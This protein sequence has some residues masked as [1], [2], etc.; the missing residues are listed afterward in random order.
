M[1]K[2]TNA[3][4]PD[5]INDLIDND[6]NLS[7]AGIKTFIKDLKLDKKAD[8][9]GGKVPASQL[10]SYVDDV[11]EFDTFED[12]P[13]P[14][15]EGKI[16]VA[17]DTGYTYRWSGERYVYIGTFSP[18]KIDYDT[19]VKDIPLGFSILQYGTLFFFAVANPAYIQKYV[20]LRLWDYQ[21]VYDFGRASKESSLGDIL[22]DK[23][24]Y[25]YTMKDIDEDEVPQN[26]KGLY[27]TQEE[28]NGN[29][30]SSH[31]IEVVEEY[32]EGGETAYEKITESNNTQ[33]NGTTFMAQFSEELNHYI[34][35]N[36]TT[37]V[38][39]LYYSVLPFNGIRIG[40]KNQ[41]TIEL[42]VLQDC[43]VWIYKYF[44]Y[45]AQT[46]QKSYDANSVVYLNGIE[47]E[48]SDDETPLQFF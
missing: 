34:G 9:V 25:P 24:Y 30:R 31:I 10:P 11:L 46:E 39:S 23:Y 28:V 41:G 19:K 44:S 35:V 32:H 5:K 22:I 20:W 29:Q 26:A 15:E 6:G 14:G 12:F 2:Y 43:Y 40:T 45:N 13:R 48:F 33:L 7:A 38:Y 1:S 8:L 21:G 47:Y 4:Y 18:I 37:N 36:N 17:L 42:N 3:K 16:Y 27:R